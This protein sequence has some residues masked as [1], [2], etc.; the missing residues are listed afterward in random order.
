MKLSEN[1]RGNAIARC[2]AYIEDYK[3]II[4]LH[5]EIKTLE[6]ELGP[7]FHPVDDKTNLLSE[8]IHRSISLYK[9]IC[10]KWHLENLIPLHPSKETLIPRKPIEIV[11]IDEWPKAIFSYNVEAGQLVRKKS[12]FWNGPIPIPDYSRVYIPLRIN[13]T[14]SDDDLCDA[15]KK[16]IREQ[17]DIAKEHLKGRRSKPKKYDPWKI[18]DLHHTYGLSLLEIARKLEGVDPLPGEKS[19]VYNEEQW[20]SYQRVRRAYKKAE[21]MIKAVEPAFTL[22][23]E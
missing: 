22:V 1:D 16:F 11:N 5:D 7:G 14:M 18:Y 12:E 2:P 9:E 6:Q 19:P 13:L 23:D 10:K 3:K 17:K 20:P 4:E 8:L 15:F 21:R